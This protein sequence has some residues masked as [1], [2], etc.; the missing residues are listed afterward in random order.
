MFLGAYRFHLLLIKLDFSM[1]AALM[2]IYGV[3]K[4]VSRKVQA[5]ENRGIHSGGQWKATEMFSKAKTYF[6]QN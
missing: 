2:A 1:F 4:N 3:F 6:S 5:S